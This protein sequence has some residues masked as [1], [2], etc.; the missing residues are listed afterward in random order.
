MRNAIYDSGSSPLAAS[1]VQWLASDG[2]AGTDGPALNPDRVSQATDSEW[3]AVHVTTRPAD[4]LKQAHGVAL[5]WIR[6]GDAEAARALTVV[7]RQAA[8]E[9]PWWRRQLAAM[10]TIVEYSWMTVAI[11]E[12]SPAMANMTTSKNGSIWWELEQL[13]A[14]LM[15]GDESSESADRV[16]REKIG[17]IRCVRWDIVLGHIALAA[18]SFFVLMFAKSRCTPWHLCSLTAALVALTQL[19]KPVGGGLDLAWFLPLVLASLLTGRCPKPPPPPQPQLPPHRLGDAY[20][21]R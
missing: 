19:W 21:G 8:A 7:Y 15:K 16:L 12:P 6:P 9:Y 10:R 14:R 17:Q 4:S 2:L 5:R 20:S 13:T 18:I 3:A 11:D 1:L